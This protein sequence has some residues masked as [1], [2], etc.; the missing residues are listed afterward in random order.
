MEEGWRRDGGR[1]KEREEGG[2][3]RDG[4][5]EVDIDLMQYLT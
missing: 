1:K 2:E 5:M 3:G 4:M